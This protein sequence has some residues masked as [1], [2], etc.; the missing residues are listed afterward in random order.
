[1]PR[2]SDARPAPDDGLTGPIPRPPAA[3]VAANLGDERD[4]PDAGP[5][6]MIGAPPAGAESWHEARTADSERPVA[7]PDG[8]PP[9]QVTQVEFDDHPAGLDPD[10]L[11]V[12]DDL[13]PDHDLDDTD[14]APEPQRR[15]GRAAKSSSG[16][17]WALVVAQWI[18]GAIGGAALWV[19]FRFLWR[20]LPVV[21]IAAA[22][23]VTV[24]LV[25]VVRAL[26]RNDDMRT[27]IFA[28]LVGLLLTVSPAILVLIGR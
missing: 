10:D 14:D 20:N 15:S 1:M 25:V 7:P 8:R 3:P 16:P 26:L 22:V 11:D 13:D 12:R 23:L 27:T 4:V 17:A 9:H 24:G 2:I 5:A 6:T 19:G 28:V 18:A 21:A